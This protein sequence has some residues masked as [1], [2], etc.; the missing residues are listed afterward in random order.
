M[1]LNDKDLYDINIKNFR[2]KISYFTQDSFLF[3][4]TIKE[5][6]LLSLDHNSE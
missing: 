6:I 1:Y 2:S 3:N 5:N 4:M